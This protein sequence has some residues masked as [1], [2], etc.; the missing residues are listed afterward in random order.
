MSLVVSI[1]LS[2]ELAAELEKR[3]KSQGETIGV[4][5]Q[6]A[7]KKLVEHDEN[8]APK[9][10]AEGAALAP[11]DIRTTDLMRELVWIRASIYHIA[12]HAQGG[13]F[14]PKPLLTEIYE[15]AKKGSR[16]HVKSAGK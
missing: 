16:D 4:Y 13:A 14:I 15:A 8:Q 2:D 5:I 3:A 10:M 12:E 1:R 9:G 11:T 6:E 7:L